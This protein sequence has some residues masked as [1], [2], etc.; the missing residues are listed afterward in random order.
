MWRKFSNY[1]KSDKSNHFL[2]IFLDFM[3]SRM[4]NRN[5]FRRHH[6]RDEDFCIFKNQMN[7]LQLNYF[8]GDDEMKQQIRDELSAAID[9]CR[10]HMY[11]LQY[12]YGTDVNKRF[13]SFYTPR[14]KLLQKL[15]SSLQ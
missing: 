1:L 6:L 11:G 15:Y 2:F 3:H 9:D 13:I 10:S 5:H 12:N 7:Q 8:S 4:I 14:L